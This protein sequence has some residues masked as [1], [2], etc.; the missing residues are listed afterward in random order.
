VRVASQFLEH[1]EPFWVGGFLPP[2][3]GFDHLNALRE[4]LKMLSAPHCEV[5]RIRYEERRSR[6]EMCAGREA[7]AQ[8]NRLSRVRKFHCYAHPTQKQVLGSVSFF[9][10]GR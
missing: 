1:A 3:D 8:R 10:R 4:C 7:L 5:L 2:T 9:G 6:A